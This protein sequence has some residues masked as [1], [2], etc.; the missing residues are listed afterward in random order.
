MATI[1]CSADHWFEKLAGYQFDPAQLP[2]AH[3][4]CLRKFINVC[5]SAQHSSQQV[6][7]LRGIPGSGKSTFIKA[8]PQLA[9]VVDNTSPHA[10]N[11]APY[12]A[13]ASA[14]GLSCK[15]ITLRCDPVVAAARCQHGVPADRIATMAVLMEE[16]EKLFP[17]WWTNE[18]VLS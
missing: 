2:A 1:V 5:G 14:Y 4:A 13:V 6:T 18:I 7:I 10:T 11:V 16:Q 8:H 15:I 3:N 12:W 9:I 17:P